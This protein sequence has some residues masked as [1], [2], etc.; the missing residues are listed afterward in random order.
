MYD[1]KINNTYNNIEQYLCSP[2]ELAL[3]KA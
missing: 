1:A 3:Y 2:G